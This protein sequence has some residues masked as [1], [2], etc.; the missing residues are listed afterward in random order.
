SA[1]CALSTFYQAGDEDTPEGL[2]LSMYR[3]MGK[4]PTI[5]GWSYKKALGQPTI[6][7]DNSLGYCEN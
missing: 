2:D 7:P 1:V 4:L 5:A 3:L 6:Y